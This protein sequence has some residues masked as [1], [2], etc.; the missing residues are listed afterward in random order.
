MQPKP[1][2]HHGRASIFCLRF[3]ENR[4]LIDPYL[5]LAVPNKNDILKSH[6]V[7]YRGDI[8]S[9]CHGRL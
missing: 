2:R 5:S 7:A 8:Q 1:G 9:C 3:N 6:H 4:R